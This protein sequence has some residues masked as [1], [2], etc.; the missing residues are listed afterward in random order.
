MTMNIRGVLAAGTFALI[1]TGLAFSART[2]AD[3]QQATAALVGL[4]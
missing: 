3:A 1:T 2:T 4:R